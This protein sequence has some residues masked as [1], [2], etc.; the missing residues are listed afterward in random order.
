MRDRIAALSNILAQQSR[1]P[2]LGSGQWFENLV[3][4]GWFRK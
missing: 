4:E 3:P 1:E 2:Q